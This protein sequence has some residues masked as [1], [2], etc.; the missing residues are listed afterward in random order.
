MYVNLFMTHYTS[1]T[2]TSFCQERPHVPSS[3]RN[4]NG[5]SDAC[6]EKFKEARIDSRSSMLA[7]RK[8][9]RSLLRRSLYDGFTF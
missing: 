8:W 3:S 2:H 6:L 5:Y 7:I 4:M 1:A 9:R